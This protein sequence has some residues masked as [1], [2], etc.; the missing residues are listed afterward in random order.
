MKRRIEENGM[1][2]REVFYDLETA[3]DFKQIAEI[4]KGPEARW[5]QREQWCLEILRR[6]NAGEKDPDFAARFPEDTAQWL[7]RAWLRAWRRAKRTREK[8]EIVGLMDACEE[9]GI[10]QERMQWR[11]GV[12]PATGERRE[13]LA[14]QARKSRVALL[15]DSDG[16]RASANYLRHQ[17]AEE[18]RTVAREIAATSPFG[19]LRLET[20]ILN[21]LEAR[22]LPARS[23]SAI[24]KAIAGIR[25]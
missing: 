5:D 4:W 25:R 21:E 24:R 22:G 16:G 17:E 3:E 2:R 6:A 15:G 20:R 23:G 19:G 18:W 10:L 1:M 7:A 13:A 8:G 12:D 9:M 14:M 11:R